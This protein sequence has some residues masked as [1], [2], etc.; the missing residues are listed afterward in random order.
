MKILRHTFV[1][2]AVLAGLAAGGC[3]ARGVPFWDPEYRDDRD[4][5]W[6]DD[7]RDRRGDWV[8]SRDGD[9][10]DRRYPRSTDRREGYWDEVNRDRWDDDHSDDYWTWGA[11]SYAVPRT[12]EMPN[13]RTLSQTLDQTADDLMDELRH[14]SR[15]RDTLGRADGPAD[16]MQTSAESFRRQVEDNMTRPDRTL[17]AYQEIKTSHIRLAEIASRRD[18]TDR[19]ERLVDRLDETVVALDRIYLRARR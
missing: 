2:A 5:D 11:Q 12:S 7:W 10:D 4:K 16:R 9:W 14:D 1:L 6:D 18:L 17:A 8:D 3:D 19:M 15:L 13:I